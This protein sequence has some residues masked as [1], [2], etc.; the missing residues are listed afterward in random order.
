MGSAADMTKFS[1]YQCS[2]CGAEFAPDE[3]TYTCPT[4]GGNLDII[5]DYDSLSKKLSPDLITTSQEASIWRYLPL[6]PVDDPGYAGSALHSVGWTPLYTPEALAEEMNLERLWIK[7]D[8]R[9]PT[10][11]FKDRASAVVVARAKEINAD[12]VVTAST[13]NA[14][15]ALAGMAAAAHHQAVI[16]APKTAPPAKV[17]QLLVFGSRVFL[18]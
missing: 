14:G 10:A 15:A 8:G 2:V 16:F 13:G 18:V 5:F 17:A 7:D 11:S 1:F 3:V 4:D 9:N 12:V 6:L